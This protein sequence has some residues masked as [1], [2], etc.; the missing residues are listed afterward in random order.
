MYVST[1]MEKVSVCTY[2]EK[3]LPITTGIRGC[4]PR[5]ESERTLMEEPLRAAFSNRSYRWNSVVCRIVV[6]FRPPKNNILRSC[7]SLSFNGTQPARV[8]RAV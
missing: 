1:R 4:H 6:E 3:Q 8:L 2:I 5:D 7:W